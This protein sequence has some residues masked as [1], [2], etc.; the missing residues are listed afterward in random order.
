MGFARILSPAG[1]NPSRAPRASIAA[2]DA[3]ETRAS[4]LAFARQKRE[5]QP[6]CRN[7]A[8]A[9]NAGDL[10]LWP[11]PVCSARRMLSQ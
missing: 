3:A 1:R 11:S 5:I 10:H 7:S 8:P 2:S 9:I 6:G 4:L